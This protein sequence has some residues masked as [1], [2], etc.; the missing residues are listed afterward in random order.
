[1]LADHIGN[2]G[3]R[4]LATDPG[5]H[6]SFTVEIHWGEGDWQ[7]YHY[8]AGSTWY[9][10]THQYLDDDP[11]GTPVDTYTVSVRVIDKDG[12][13]DIATTTVTVNNVA[14]VAGE[15]YISGQPNEEFSF[16]KYNIVSAYMIKVTHF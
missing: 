5:I 15:P 1:V 3:L 11:T 4:I 10:E 13:F 6:D 8:D 2:T 16:L 12:G 9:S 7:T 14:L